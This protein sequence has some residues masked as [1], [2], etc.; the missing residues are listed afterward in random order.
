MANYHCKIRNIS[1][2]ADGLG[3]SSVASAA[4]RAGENLHNEREDKT[5]YFQNRAGDV[6]HKQIYP[7]SNAPK[8]AQERS[9]FWNNTELAERY[10][11]AR[12]AKEIIV[13]LPYELNREQFIKPI[14]Q[15]VKDTIISKHDIAVDVVVHRYGR[16]RPVDTKELK[17][18]RAKRIPF[19]VGADADKCDKEHVKVLIDKH[20]AITGYKLYQPHAHIMMPLRSFDSNSKTG[21]AKKKNREIDSRQQILLW[22]KAWQDCLNKQFERLGLAVRI[23]CLAKQAANDNQTDEQSFDYQMIYTEGKK[24]EKAKDIKISLKELL[25]SDDFADRLA[26]MPK[27][28]QDLLRNEL[29]DSDIEYLNEEENSRMFELWGGMQNNNHYNRI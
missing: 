13:T 28:R 22:R 23:S 29:Y 26:L 2:G 21:F 12:T 14:E 3:K 25:H 27:E 8:W 19:L 5:H 4:Y 15:Y 24:E 9:K 20:G 1:R 11:N 7:A 17:Q 6:C 18:W 16:A 10:K